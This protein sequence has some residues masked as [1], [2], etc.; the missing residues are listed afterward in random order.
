MTRRVVTLSCAAGAHAACR[1]R[2]AY[3]PTRCECTCH[4]THFREEVYFLRDGSRR[5]LVVCAQCGA[6]GDCT[7]PIAPPYDQDA[8]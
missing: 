6:V 8:P 5:A 3:V 2:S 4:C 1:G 7:T